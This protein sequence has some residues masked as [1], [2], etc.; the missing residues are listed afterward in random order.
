MFY[1][2]SASLI[3]YVKVHFARINIQVIKK[4]II[5]TVDDDS[6]IIGNI[7]ETI[8]E[9]QGKASFWTSTPKKSIDRCEECLDK[10]E[11]VDCIVKHM[12]RR[13]GSARTKFF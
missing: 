3:S 2:I 1:L 13:H 10:S 7:I 12:L 11:C 5:W 8:E 4:K 6:R 9:T